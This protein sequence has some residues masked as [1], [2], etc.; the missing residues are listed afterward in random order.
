MEA[1]RISKRFVDFFSK[2][3]L[4]C[5]ETQAGGLFHS[6]FWTLPVP[7]RAGLKFLPHSQEDI[8]GEGGPYELDRDWQTVGET[9]GERERRKP[10]QIAR[11][12]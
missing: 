11:R 12:D 2:L 10:G 5:F 9:A 8:F 3:I 7:V 6:H 4:A 1:A